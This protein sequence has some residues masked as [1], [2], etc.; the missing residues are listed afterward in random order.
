MQTAEAQGR[1]IHAVR[2]WAFYSDVALT[3]DFLLVPKGLERL[4]PLEASTL[5]EPFASSHPY[6]V[7]A[8]GDSTLRF[9]NGELDKRGLALENMGGWDAQTIAG[10]MMTATHGSGLAFGPIASQVVSL[11]VVVEQGELLPI[12]PD[13]GITDPRASSVICRR[14]QPSKCA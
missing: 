13:R 4:L 6:Y 3:D 11:Q 14:S 12:E 9:L 8:A 1:H 5:R 7:R 2:S 10:V